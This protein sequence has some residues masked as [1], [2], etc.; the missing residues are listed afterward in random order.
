MK[1]FKHGVLNIVR[2]VSMSRFSD[3]FARQVSDNEKLQ[4]TESCFIE[5]TLKI[6]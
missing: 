1:C 5:L 6:D 4:A 2:T 3:Y